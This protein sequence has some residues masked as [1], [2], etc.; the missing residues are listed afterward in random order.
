MGEPLDNYDATV[1][2]IRLM[3]LPEAL[4]LSSRKVTLSTA[5]QVDLIKSFRRKTSPL[6]WRY[7]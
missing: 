4:K 7:H 6:T 1:D 5:G 3:I 2:A